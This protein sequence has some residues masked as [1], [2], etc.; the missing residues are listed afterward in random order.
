MRR[1]DDPVDRRLHGVIE[2]A[3]IEL[4]VAPGSDLSPCV[5]PDAGAMRGAF[6]CVFCYKRVDRWAEVFPKLTTEA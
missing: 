3:M 2:L 4:R 1:S 5:P 6:G